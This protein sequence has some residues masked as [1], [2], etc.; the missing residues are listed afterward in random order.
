MLTLDCRNDSN[1]FKRR[2]IPPIS[3]ISRHVSSLSHHKI[4]DTFLQ[5]NGRHLGL[6]LNTD[7]IHH[8]PD[9][10]CKKYTPVSL[11]RVISLERLHLRESFARPEKVKVRD[12]E[13]PSGRRRGAL[14]NNGRYTPFTGLY[15]SDRGIV[16]NV[17][18]RRRKKIVINKN[19]ELIIRL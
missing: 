8:T 18:G 19:V 2:V 1:M 14:T 13:C 6:V 3:I 11:K 16:M 7:R 9:T 5:H 12:Y 17:P 4:D 15:F 10:C